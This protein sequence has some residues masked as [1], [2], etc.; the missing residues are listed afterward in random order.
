[1][2]DGHIYDPVTDFCTLCG[3]HAALIYSAKLE[4]KGGENVVAIS[5]IVQAKAAQE[6]RL[7]QYLEDDGA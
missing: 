7:R 2:S 5:H 6:D 4:C 1:M 3:K